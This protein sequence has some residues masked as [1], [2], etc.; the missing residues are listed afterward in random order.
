MFNERRNGIS[1]AF[2]IFIFSVTVLLIS[3]CSSTSAKPGWMI[4]YPVDNN[5]Y[6]G[7]GGSST[8]NQAEDNEIARQRALSTLAA[9]ISAEIISEINI[10]ATSD[11]KG[12]A[13]E[14]VREE[15]TQHVAQ[16]LKAIE[17]VG[18][19]YS[20]S[21]GYW[22]YLRLNKAQWRA[23]QLREM[24]D[25]ER[26]VKNIVEPV[27]GNKSR[28]AADAF[29]VL[30]DGWTIVNESPYPGMID[31]VL[32]GENGKLIDLL[33]RQMALMAGFITINMGDEMIY[34][35]A[36]RPVKLKFSVDTSDGRKP[37]QLQI[38]LLER[39]SGKQ[40]IGCTTSSNGIYNDSVDLSGLAAG[41]NYVTA[42]LNTDVLGYKGKAVQINLPKAEFLID[43]QKIKAGLSVSY[44]GDL[45]EIEN[46]NGIYGSIKAML[47]KSLPVTIENKGKHVFQLDF[48]LNYRNAPPNDYG[49]SIIYIKANISILKNGASVYTYETNEYKGA[50][51][52]WS[53]A[54][55]KGLD[56]LFENFNKES[57]FSTEAGAAFSL[58]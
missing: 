57:N 30:I 19:Y 13:E 3:G 41:K 25:I 2:V 50:G 42:V 26:R 35:E 58:D 17:T 49:F 28:T 22:Y 4:N 39:S 52:N 56:K 40:L 10:R 32:M 5:Y 37:G 31:A 16:N 7:I 29:T 15:I 51:L 46:Q 12:N 23:I 20:S 54:N 38:D 14:Q 55:S 1:A 44:T 8:G 53:Q 48:R 9:E 34:A 18:S 36:G 43:L 11:D 45:E 27:L 21:D 24:K 6:I 47:S 33:E